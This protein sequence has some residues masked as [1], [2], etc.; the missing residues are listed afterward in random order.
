MAREPL[1]AG[2]V[3]TETGEPVGTAV[4]GDEPMYV[5]PDEG[6]NHHVASREVD[7]EVL[8]QLSEIVLANKDLVAEGAMKLMGQEDLFTK[9]MI[10]SSLKQWD[11]HVAQLL[12]AG[13]PEQ[14]RLTLGMMGFRVVLNYHGEVVR[15][16]MPGSVGDSG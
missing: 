12:E 6:F 14:A 10:D 11:K 8:R 1:F 16:E 9:A 2:L 3:T 5:V 15:V 13:L 7:R 4:L